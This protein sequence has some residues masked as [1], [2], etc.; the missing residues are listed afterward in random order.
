[1]D[2]TEPYSVLEK[3]TSQTSR[4]QIKLLLVTAHI[5]GLVV[6]LYL[7]F[8]LSLNLYF[9]WLYLYF[10]WLYLYYCLCPTA[11]GPSHSTALC[12]PASS[13]LSNRS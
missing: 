7:Y 6:H 9:L 2:S 3:N 13:F 1:M 4:C 8:Y 10:L 5:V 11:V 12:M